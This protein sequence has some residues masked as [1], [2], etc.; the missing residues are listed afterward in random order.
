MGV[1]LG[2]LSNSN[3]FMGAAI[4]PMIGGGVAAA[5]TVGLRQVT[6]T[7]EMVVKAQENAPWVGLAAGGLASLALYN[8]VSR[9]AGIAALSGT[10]AVAAAFVG[11]KLAAAKTMAG[12]GAVVPEYR[13][14]LGAVVMESPASRPRQFSGGESVSLGALNASAFGT[15]F[16][17]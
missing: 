15:S 11:S 5:V 4:P 14:G 16:A 6:S 1:G 3:S 8:M 7:N 2:S 10:V 9:T 13:D 17:V 12:L